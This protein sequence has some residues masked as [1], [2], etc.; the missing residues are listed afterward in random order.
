MLGGALYPL[1]RTI[2]ST[3]K[4]ILLHSL[5]L[6]TR[7]YRRWSLL[8]LHLF[9]L[10]SS[11]YYETTPA[12]EV[13]TISNPTMPLYSLR[14]S[15]IIIFV[16][17]VTHVYKYSLLPPPLAFLPQLASYSPGGSFG[18]SLTTFYYTYL[19]CSSL[20]FPFHKHITLYR[21]PFIRLHVVLLL[22]TAS[23]LAIPRTSTS[24]LSS[25]VLLHIAWCCVA[26]ILTG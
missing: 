14:T 11:S 4:Q 25:L 19:R 7:T 20:Y 9:L 1:H 6:E 5:A 23:C 24:V 22:G 3:A 10:R 2:V 15:V 13:V 26:L 21:Y 16:L 17:V 12:S 18:R 8:P